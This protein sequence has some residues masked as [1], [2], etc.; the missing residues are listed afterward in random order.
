M[1]QLGTISKPG[2]LASLVFS[3]LVHVLILVFVVGPYIDVAL[4]REQMI[5]DLSEESKEQTP[6]EKTQ[7]GD[8]SLRLARRA[9][10]G[11]SSPDRTRS[12]KET[13]ELPEH[14]DFAP[15]DED[16]K[17]IPRS[18]EG[19]RKE[20]TLRRVRRSIASVWSK[21]EPPCPGIAELRLK[22]AP[23]GELMSIWITRLKGRSELGEYL[24][25]LLG[26]AAPYRQAMLNATRPVV[27]DCRFE[28]SGR[29]S[30]GRRAASAE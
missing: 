4:E 27:F 9:P 13:G 24:R 15:E 10:G 22:L 20:R 28:I 8:V 21:A 1:M 3:V 12:D 16:K 26:S 19:E 29:A 11:E 5:L 7:K 17:R 25:G 14:V 6:R 23:T 18:V 30:G 2:P